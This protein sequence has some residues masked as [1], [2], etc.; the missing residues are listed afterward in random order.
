MLLFFQ[1]LVTYPGARSSRS[2]SDSSGNEI[3][4]D[5]AGTRFASSGNTCIYV[6]EDLIIN[7]H[8]THVA[9]D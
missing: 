8:D 2:A 4:A 3:A 5:R 7:T 6:L 9:G 1:S